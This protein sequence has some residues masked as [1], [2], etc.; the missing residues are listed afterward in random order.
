V[1]R[2]ILVT[3]ALLIRCA[4]PLAA[5]QAEQAGSK[6]V[7]TTNDAILFGAFTAGAIALST[8]DPRITHWFQ[9]SVRQYNKSLSRL[10]SNFTKVQE[11]TLTLTALATYGIGRLSKSV[12][13][14]VNI[15]SLDLSK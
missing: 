1:S 3:T 5:Q 7:F 13:E 6:T 9:D 11:T 14:V 4:M 15:N 2:S 10:A 12:G 8:V